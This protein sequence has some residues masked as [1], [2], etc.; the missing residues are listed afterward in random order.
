MVEW[1]LSLA[2][3][4]TALFKTATGRPEIAEAGAIYSAI[5][6]QV[7]AP[8]SALL[9]ALKIYFEGFDIA[10]TA[11]KLVFEVSDRVILIPWSAIW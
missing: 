1:F 4:R 8:Y 9:Y 10:Y 6:D 11:I 2:P 3:A 5:R 7:L